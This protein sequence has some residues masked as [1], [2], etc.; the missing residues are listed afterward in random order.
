MNKP[1]SHTSQLNASPAG[2]LNFFRLLL[3]VVL[4]VRLFYAARVLLVPDE[5]F[6]W[7]LSRHLAPGYLDHP[8]M[9]ALLI[10]IG[11]HVVGSTELGVRLLGVLMSVAAMVIIVALS[12]RVLHEARAAVWVAVIWLTSPL[13]A[14]LG[15]I[16]TPDTPAVFFSV[17]ALTMVCLIVDSDDQGEAGKSGSACLWL[18]FGLFCGLGMVSKYT[19]VLL[20][21]SV[22][23]AMLF[24]RR[25]RVH[26]RRPWIYLSGIL[27]LL[28]F[29]PV[30]W[31]NATH[32]WVSFLFQLHHGTASHG[33]QE[34]LSNTALG[35]RP[36]KDIGIYI[37][38]QAAIW[39]PVLFG[40]TI[41]VLVEY[42]VRYVRSARVRSALRTH[43][44]NREM[45]VRSADP[46]ESEARNQPLSQL[47]IVLLWSGTFP[48]VLFAVAAIR[49]HHTEANWPGF[50]YF[51]ISLLIA[52]WL[53]QKWS[54]RRLKWAHLGVRVAL[55]GLV[56]IYVIAFPAVSQKIGA[57]P[58]HVPH[59]LMDLNGWRE[60]GRWLGNMSKMDDAPIIT[61]RHQDAG[62]AAFYMPG[63]PEVWCISI[64]T[65]PTA[66]DYFD[67]KPD[68]AKIPQ[69]IWVGGNYNLFEKSYGYVESARV[70]DMIIMAH[71]SRN[72]RSYEAFLLSRLPR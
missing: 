34:G 12:R 2:E 44:S 15:A 38:G 26:Y 30:I 18:L 20:P 52:R 27:A 70:S 45:M 49:S 64:G 37:G 25:G 61:N 41:V 23:L 1:V 53:S 21:A 58:V 50:A 3:P 59:A 32:E 40:I 24:S 69:V 6:Y 22:A 42:W 62:E 55:V 29:S 10:W 33:P 11:T 56:G 66:F 14:A 19:A 57:L 65:R 4:V 28:V 43:L 60:Y 31:W 72:M 54:G 36:L 39:T 13:L 17:C 71:G 48:L 46:T 9:I 47:E 5:A 8:P 35:L 68:F 63:Q 7:V 16:F 51:P 67:E